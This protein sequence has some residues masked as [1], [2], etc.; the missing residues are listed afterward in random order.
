MLPR[1]LAVLNSKGGVGK[2]SICTNVAGL[3]AAADYRVLIVD[4]DPQGN[5][6]NDLGFTD[7]TDRG[8]SLLHAATSGAPLRPLEAVRPNL[9]VVPGGAL[10]EDMAGA[11][12]ARAIRGDPTDTAVRDALAPL[13]NEYD[14]ILFDCPPNNRPL[15]RMALTAAQYVVI[16]TKSDRASCDGLYQVADLFT[17]VR[18]GQNPYLELLGLVLFGVGSRAQGIARATRKTINERLGQDGL[19]F[20]TTIRHVEGP[21]QECRDRGQLAHELEAGLGDAKRERLEWLR[22][23]RGSGGR[24]R[25][26]APR[27]ADSAPGLAEDYQQLAEE[28]VGRINERAAVTA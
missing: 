18:A 6:A 27:V 19:W 24:H 15:Q 9:D 10:I 7:R 21:A 13:T 16:P 1:A 4:L 3:L 22:K 12:A 8:Q 26:D 25:T 23:S 17:A 20:H 28:L 5:T 11:L 2:T 14:L